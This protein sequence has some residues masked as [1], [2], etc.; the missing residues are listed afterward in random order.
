MSVGDKIMTSRVPLNQRVQ[1]NPPSISMQSLQ[2][3]SSLNGLKASQEKLKLS[4]MSVD[5]ILEMASQRLQ[6]PQSQKTLQAH[7]NSSSQSLQFTKLRI[8][9]DAQPPPLGII[10]Q[11]LNSSFGNKSGIINGLINSARSIQNPSNANNSMI[12]QP[13]PN[14]QTPGPAISSH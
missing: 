11:K 3:P 6:K 4:R 14:T 9:P 5:D 7:T 12:E 10:Q 2:H 13:V 1:N 8:Q